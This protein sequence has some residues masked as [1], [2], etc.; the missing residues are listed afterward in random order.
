MTKQ[1]NN[2]WVRVLVGITVF[3]GGCAVN[4]LVCIPTFHE[5]AT[6]DAASRGGA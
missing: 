1:L 2:I 6:W 3:F 5:Q 4:C